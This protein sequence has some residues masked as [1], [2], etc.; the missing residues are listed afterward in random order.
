MLKKSAKLLHLIGNKDP[1]IATD[2]SEVAHDVIIL[3][4]ET[5]VSAGACAITHPDR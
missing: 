3:A 4:P 1:P 2:I 5:V